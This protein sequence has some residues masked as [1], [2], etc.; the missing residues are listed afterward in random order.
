[1]AGKRAGTKGANGYRMVSVSQTRLLEHRVI[2]ALTTGEWPECVDHANGDVTDN[3]LG[4]LRAGSKSD[5]TCNQRLRADS[6]TGFK[7]VSIHHTGKYAARIYK[8]NRRYY[9]GVF[10]TKETAFAAYTAAAKKLH[11][12]FSNLG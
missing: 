7:G 10:D 11:G 5:N 9:L 6:R 2:Y 12:E 4:N 8:D 1:M 3:R